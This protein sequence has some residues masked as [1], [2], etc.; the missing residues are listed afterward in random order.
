MT[1]NIYI[2]DVVSIDKGITLYVRIN[3]IGY[4]PIQQKLVQRRFTV[5]T[6][7]DFSCLDLKYTRR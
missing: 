5:S 7:I 6:A 3:L 1:I 2:C 4:L